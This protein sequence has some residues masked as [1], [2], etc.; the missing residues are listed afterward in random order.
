MITKETRSDVARGV[1]LI[2]VFNPRKIAAMSN[3]KKNKKT[4]TTTTLARHYMLWRRMEKEVG[5][6][7]VFQVP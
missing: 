7:R 2:H 5:P 1:S 6:S 3:E 4:I